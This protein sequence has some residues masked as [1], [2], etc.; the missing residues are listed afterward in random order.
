VLD[1]LHVSIIAF[2]E[3]KSI[4]SLAN[5]KNTVRWLIVSHTAFLYNMLN[6]SEAGK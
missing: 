5:K 4:L 2:H 1:S 3:Y 6:N